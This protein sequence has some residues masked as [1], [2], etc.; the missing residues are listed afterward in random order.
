M[1]D[2]RQVVLRDLEGVKLIGSR[3]RDELAAQPAKVSDHLGYSPERGTFVRTVLHLDAHA[4]T[5]SAA[6]GGTRAATVDHVRLVFGNDGML[7]VTAGNAGFVG[8]P[9]NV[10]LAFGLD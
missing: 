1:K 7:Y 2:P 8:T 6:A 3:Y 5:F 10:L 9:G 4:L